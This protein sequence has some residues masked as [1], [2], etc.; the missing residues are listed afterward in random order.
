MRWRNL[1]RHG[2][3]GGSLLGAATA[4]VAADP[5]QEAAP[6]TITVVFGIT[7]TD[8]LRPMIGLEGRTCLDDRVEAMVRVEVGGGS[9]RLIGGLRVFPLAGDDDGYHDESARDFVGVEAGAGID[10][11]SRPGLHLAATYG[12]NAAY[13]GAQLLSP[14]GGE[15]PRRVTLL[16][17][18]APWAWKIQQVA[19][20][21]PL[22]RDGR[23]WRPAIAALPAAGSAEARAVRDH[24][25]SSAQLELSS[26]WTFLRLA[27]ELAAVGA[28]AALVAAALDAA[29][30]EVAHAELCAAAAGGVSLVPLPP[31]AA[32][33]R[34]A[35]RSAAALATLAREAWLEGCL[36]ETAAAEEA[37]LAAAEAAG[38]A[39]AMLATIARDEAGHA[40]LAWAVLRWVQAEAPAI[41]VAA[42][43]AIPPAP[44]RA[45]A[46]RAFDPALARYG[47]PSPAITAAAWA[48]ARRGVAA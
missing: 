23:P 4:P 22:V 32:R 15:Q 36:N 24:F 26:V 46:P 13:F 6:S 45:P 40:A 2:L 19:E 3:L 41:A 1:V 31:A 47:V 35:S 48:H 30:D 29:D 7:A 34:F 25:A 12:M 43:A 16:G 17:G 18:V 33:P 10:L 21:R 27:A 14:L 20:G 9:P 28:P 8:R 38:P 44:A 39:R 37:R 11:E 5:C 42:L